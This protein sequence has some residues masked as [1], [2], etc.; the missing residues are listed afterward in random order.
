M[1]SN[2]DNNL[3]KCLFVV[4]ILIAMTVVVLPAVN[5]VDENYI[6][7]KKLEGHTSKL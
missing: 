2:I 1:E 7:S 4:P 5:N 6:Q 3:L